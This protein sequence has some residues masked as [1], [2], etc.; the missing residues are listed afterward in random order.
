VAVFGDDGRHTRAAI[1]VSSLPR[2]AL[3]EVQMIVEI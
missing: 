3:V 2:N 1:G